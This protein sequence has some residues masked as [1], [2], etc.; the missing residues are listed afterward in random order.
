MLL[1]GSVATARAASA[2]IGDTVVDVIPV[3]DVAAVQ[4]ANGVVPVGVPTA[5]GVAAVH[6]AAHLCMGLQVA[7]HSLIAAL[8]LDVV[9]T[10]GS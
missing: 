1:L 6:L 10:A 9:V 3:A 7:H 5:R 2:S 4:G 8:V